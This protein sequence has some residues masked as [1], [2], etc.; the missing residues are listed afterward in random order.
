M[1]F[2]VVWKTI[3]GKYKTALDQFLKTG[4]RHPMYRKVTQ[5]TIST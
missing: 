4:G 2:M 5:V 1:R 3:P